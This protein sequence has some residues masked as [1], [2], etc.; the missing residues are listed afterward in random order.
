MA[1]N[2]QP[3]IATIAMIRIPDE[4]PNANDSKEINPM[5]PQI[6]ATQPNIVSE[7]PTF[8]SNRQLNSF[9]VFTLNLKILVAGI[10]N[11]SL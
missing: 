2:R 3:V 9:E 5:D 7:L 10:A 6:N 11:G 4:S 1:L 8:I